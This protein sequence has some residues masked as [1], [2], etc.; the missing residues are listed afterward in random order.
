MNYLLSELT[1]ESGVSLSV[2]TIVLDFV[3]CL[4]T[5]ELNDAGKRK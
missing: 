1:V 5:Y 3:D 2:E 4:I